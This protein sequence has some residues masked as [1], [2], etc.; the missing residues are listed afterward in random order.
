MRR[1]K[2]FAVLTSATVLSLLVT[3][4][5]GSKTTDKTDP[6]QTN[7]DQAANS[8]V[9]GGTLT[10]GTF[11]DITTLNPIYIDET[12][13]QE[14]AHLIFAFLYDLD[15]KGNAEANDWTIAAELPKISADGL[16]Y[17]VKIKT[18]AKWSDNTP[19]TADDVIFTFKAQANPDAASPQIAVFDKIKDVKAVSQDTVEFE[20]KEPY[21]PLITEAFVSPI[22]PAAAFKGIDPK[23]Y[24]KVPFG[25]DPAKT[26]TSG[27]WKWSEWVQKQ[28]V[29]LDRNTNYWSKK[30]NIETIIYKIYADQNTEVQGML[31]GDVDL[32]ELIP[33]ASLP[34]V[35]NK[36]EI[37]LIEQAGPIYDYLGFNFK[38]E[39]FP[40]GVSPF[41]GIKTRQALAHA[42][43]RQGMVDSV[44]KGHGVLLNGPFLPGSWSDAGTAIN[45]AY[46]P[47][48]AK[49]LLAEDGWKAGSDGTL[50]KDG[51]KFEF[52]L[53][54]NTGN[55]RRE[56][57]GAI[58][59]Q[60]LKDVG[61]KVELEPLD[62]SA[63]I[64]NNVT[65]GKY[66]AVLLGWN[67]DVDPN[68]ESIFSSKYFPPA[69][70]NSGWYKN[71]KVDK[72]WADGYKQADQ[73]KRR[74]I[75]AD[76]AKEITTDLPYVFLYQQNKNVAVRDRVQFKDTDKPILTLPYGH[77]YHIQN[78]WVTK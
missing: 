48:K 59:Q 28:H 4:C 25:T 29:K 11:S 16:K 54:F 30:A 41:A 51:K 61:I 22:I 9:D 15:A 39:N 5:S 77:I 31:S 60:N 70:Q 6:N 56:S 10:W 76:L 2:W 1:S 71:E 75:Y 45:Y 52:K 7:T 42:L 50:E 65:P 32:A 68:A 53:Q 49:A 74:Q 43:N 8:P 26:I 36:K 78:W 19:I 72:L 23:E 18:N 33:V 34:T 24:K 21:A 38:G 44:L 20:L 62:F 47:A 12:G 13:S 3:A 57:V 37:K 67:L 17:T 69:G 58:I 64:E 63:W 40:S 35:Q 46:D 14:I 55:K 27:P 73:A 66:Q